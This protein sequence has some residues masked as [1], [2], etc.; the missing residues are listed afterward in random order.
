LQRAA[1]E[2]LLCK[3]IND[4]FL[5][6]KCRRLVEVLLVADLEAQPIAGGAGRLAQHQ[7]VMLL[8]LAAAQ[9]DRLVVAILDMKPDGVLVELAAGIQ[10]HHVEHDMA[11]PDDVERWIEDMCRHGHMM[12]FR[13]IN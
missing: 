4:A 2:R 11:A 8:F 3:A 12:L 7:R 13:S 6:E 1:L 9:I 10:V 5:R